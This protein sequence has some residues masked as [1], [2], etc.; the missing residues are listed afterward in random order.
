MDDLHDIVMYRSLETDEEEEKP[1]GIS[2][3]VIIIILIASSILLVTGISLAIRVKKKSKL[4]GMIG[5]GRSKGITTL[6]EKAA[7]LQKDS[8]PRAEAV[9]GYSEVDLSV[10]L[11]K[12]R[13]GSKIAIAIIV[14]ATIIIIASILIITGVMDIGAIIQPEEPG[15]EAELIEEQLDEQQLLDQTMS[16]LENDEDFQE[17]GLEF[18]EIDQVEIIIE[19]MPPVDEDDEFPDPSSTQSTTSFPE[20]SPGRSENSP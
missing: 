11:K 7:A 18:E 8:A 10:K 17:P 6:Q 16:P 2:T 9:E 15:L 19:T 1:K 14:I 12:D 3:N 13:V 5:E 20:L 4:L